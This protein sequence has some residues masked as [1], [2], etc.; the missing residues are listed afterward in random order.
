L[1]PYIIVSRDIVNANKPTA[2]GVPLTSKV[3][4][5]NSYRILLPSDELI[6][7]AGCPAFVD[8]VALCDHVRVL[9]LTRVRKKVGV[10]SQNALFGVGL[11]L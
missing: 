4:K 1:R 2:V 11:G 9:D 7:D 3:H 8:S 10:V 5:A 6:A